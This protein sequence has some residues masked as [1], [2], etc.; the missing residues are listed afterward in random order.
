MV[1]TTTRYTNGKDETINHGDTEAQRK[2][3]KAK[4]SRF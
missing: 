1:V 3:G 4:V 2:A